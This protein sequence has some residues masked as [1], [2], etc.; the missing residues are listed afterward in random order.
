MAKNQEPRTQNQRYSYRNLLLWQK[1][2][3]LT[4]PVVEIV[5]KLPRDPAAQVIARQVAGSASSVAANIAQ[6]HGRF[7]IPAHRNHLSIAK[8]SACETDS[9]LDLLRR[10]GYVHPDVEQELHEACDEVIRML[11][12]KIIQFERKASPDHTREEAPAY[13]AEDYA[14][15]E[16]F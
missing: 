3:A 16:R 4:L 11:T 8:G 13:T 10:A 9:W 1:A 2:Q 6:G 7:S 14:T 12:A 15:S 5:A